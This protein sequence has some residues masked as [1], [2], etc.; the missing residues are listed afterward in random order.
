MSAYENK[1]I[2]CVQ[3]PWR[4]TCQMECTTNCTC[5]LNEVAIISNCT[6]GRVFRNPVL[7]PTEVNVTS[8]S[9]RRTLH[10]I[11]QR[12]FEVAGLIS[13][14]T[15]YLSHNALQEIESDA[16]G[17]LVSLERLYLSY[18]GLQEMEPGVF[19]GLGSLKQLRLDN[20]ALQEIEPGMFGGLG[21]L[22]ELDL[23]HNALQDLQPSIFDGLVSLKELDLS[24]NALQ[25]IEP[26]VFDGLVSL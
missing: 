21:S 12:A 8:L 7:Y 17:G 19:G 24:Y 4:T 9:W 13:L 10:R 1:T 25:E 23:S 22:E 14:T 6:D 16:F 15:L 20:N 3:W 26:S 2:E 11:Q 5:T 18:N